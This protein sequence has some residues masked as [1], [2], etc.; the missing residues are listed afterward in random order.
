MK[1]SAGILAFRHTI[2]NGLQVLL[3]HPGGP[4]FAKK[5]EG[6][7][8]IPKG[9]WAPGEDALSVAQREFEEETGNMLT[10]GEF[11]ALSP[12]KIKS[13]KVI[14]AWAI[15]QDF[16]TCY[17]RSNHFE[18]QWPPRSGKMQSFPE[19]DKAEWFDVTSALLKIHMGQKPFIHELT[20][21]LTSRATSAQQ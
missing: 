18:M 11:I 8:S 3:V 5:D 20:Q 6:V 2:E 19:V 14:S 1:Q 13:G 17:I 16:T 10:D 7:W 9:E 21:L 12:V 4:Y 15:E